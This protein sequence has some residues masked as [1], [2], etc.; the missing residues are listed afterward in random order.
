MDADGISFGSF[1]I[2][3]IVDHEMNSSDDNLL[4]SLDIGTMVEIHGCKFHF[5]WDCFLVGYCGSLDLRA[6]LFTN[7]LNDAYC[8]IYILIFNVNSNGQINKILFLWE[9]VVFFSY[10]AVLKRILFCCGTEI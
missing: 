5:V 1:V 7:F 10:I 3:N 4:E 6:L 9:N 8:K 2:N